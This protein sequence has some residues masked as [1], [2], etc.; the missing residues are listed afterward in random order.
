MQSARILGTV[1]LIDRSTVSA[2]HG[3]ATLPITPRRIAMAAALDVVA[4]LAFVVIGRDE[5]DEESSL[6]GVVD[7]AAPFLI[8][9]VVA[10]L[11]TQ[12]WR[13]PFDLRT[14]QL[15]V[16]ATVVVGMV[17]RAT[18][19]D[20]GVAVVFIIVTTIF[21]GITMIGWRFASARLASRRSTDR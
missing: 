6:S 3:S 7:T 18:A 8:G 11:A 10:W 9:L 21:F 17:L 20:E 2:E 19:F 12:A 13:R 1:N 4:V 16:A 15:V 14:G 5:H